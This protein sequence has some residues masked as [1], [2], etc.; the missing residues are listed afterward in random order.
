MR[1]VVSWGAWITVVVLVSI[2]TV[3][4]FYPEPEPEPVVVV[5]ELPVEEYIMQTPIEPE[6]PFYSERDLECLALNAYFE[7]RNQ[8]VAGQIA[9]SQVVMNRVDSPRFPNTICDVINQGPT[10]VNWKGNEMPKRNQCHFSWWCDG[11]S[12]IP[13][14]MDTYQKILDTVTNLVYSETIDITAGS[15]HY[16]ADYVKP[17]WSLVFEKTVVIDDHIFYRH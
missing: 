5:S 3:G 13:K 7:S 8:S 16:H 1:A 10:Y 14:D 17:D 2:T 9:V 15:T 6:V 4:L 11:K 12:D